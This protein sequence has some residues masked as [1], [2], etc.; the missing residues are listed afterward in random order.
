MKKRNAFIVII[1]LLGIITPSWSD[2][3]KVR[4]IDGNVYQT[5]IIGEKEWFAENLRV[6]RYNNGDAISTSLN[7]AE[8][9]STREGAYAIYPHDSIDGHS[10]DE[11]VLKTYGA[12]YNWF[13]VDDP[14]GLC[15]A[16]W[17][18][19]SDD[20]WT[21]LMEY[22]GGEY[23]A[24]RQLKATGNLE[25]GDGLWYPPNAG[26]TNETGFSAIPGGGRYRDGHY[27]L[28]GSYGSWWSS[29]ESSS[30]HSWS[31]LMFRNFDSLERYQ[32]HK[33]SGFS[34]RCFRDVDI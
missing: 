9:S 13:A 7:D 18:V 30:A 25:E 34:V 24:G 10:S 17:S 20:D 23:I 22:L 5:V 31:Y 21:I 12:L 2:E 11:D 32:Y 29:S 19:P 3:T 27:S 26:A 15:P 33:P 1:L 28:I 14:R 16:G 4:D 8:W 6:F